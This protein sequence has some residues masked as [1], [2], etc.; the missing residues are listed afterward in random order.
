L[1]IK[2]GRLVHLKLPSLTRGSFSFMCDGLVYR[3]AKFMPFC[4]DAARL[5]DSVTY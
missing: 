3:P 4:C 5:V 1:Q 2:P